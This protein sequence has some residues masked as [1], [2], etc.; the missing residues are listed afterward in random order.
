MKALIKRMFPILLERRGARR[1]AWEEFNTRGEYELTLLPRLVDRRKAA[2]DVGGNIGVYTYHLSRLC[3]HVTV[4]EP[5]P[6]YARRLIRLSASNVRV[7]QAGLSSEPGEAELRIPGVAGGEDQGM[8]SLE[9]AAVPDAHLSRAFS[10]PLRRL[11]D[12]DLR[13][14]GFIKIDVEGHEEA[15]LGGATETIRRERPNLLVEI[16]ERHNPGG[17]QRIAHLLAGL[18]YAGVFHRG[19]VAHPLERFDQESDQRVTPELET[20]GHNRRALAYVNN[21]VFTPS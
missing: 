21:F 16:E 20:A 12:Y 7:E 9:K 15:A 14:V 5:N 13:G 11:D 3:R 18:G 17:L 6:D 1:F 10:V 19:G 8:G 2:V 4:F